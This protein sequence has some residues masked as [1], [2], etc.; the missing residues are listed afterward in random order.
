MRLLH[1]K[2]QDEKEIVVDNNLAEKTEIIVNVAARTA[3]HETFMSSVDHCEFKGVC[4]N[5][6]IGETQHYHI[7]FWNWGRK[8]SMH[9]SQHLTQAKF[10]DWLHFAANVAYP[11]GY[12]HEEGKPEPLELKV[13]NL[14]NFVDPA[15]EEDVDIKEHLDNF[16][17]LEENANIDWSK[18]NYDAN[19]HSSDISKFLKALINWRH[20]QWR[21]FAINRDIWI[22]YYWFI[23]AHFWLFSSVC[24]CG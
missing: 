7:G 14:D 1:R 21:H 19:K 16:T 18:I 17:S 24:S 6:P 4:Y 20:W 9:F 5:E 22:V 11:V 12:I 23:F 10:L 15:T 13:K 2:P 3:Y 8:L